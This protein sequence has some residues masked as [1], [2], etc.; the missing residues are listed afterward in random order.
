VSEL[1]A[2]DVVK[3]KNILLTREALDTLVAARSA[4]AKAPAEK[5]EKKS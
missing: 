3:H 1:N 4:S 2:Y 5:K